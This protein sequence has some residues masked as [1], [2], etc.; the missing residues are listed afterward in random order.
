MKRSIFLILV[1]VLVA[2]LAMP[3]AASAQDVQAAAAA[4]TWKS[5]VMYFN[6]T[7]GGTGTGGETTMSIT[8]TG[9]VKNPDGSETPVSGSSDAQPVYAYQVGQVFIGTSGDFEGSAVISSGVPLVA[10]YKQFPAKNDDGSGDTNYSPLL[11]T[12]FDGST[13]A[14][15]GRFYIPTVLR[16]PTYISQVGV[17][18]VEPDL[19]PVDVTVHFLNTDGQEVGS[20]SRPDL[21]GGESFVFE[22]TGDVVGDMFDGSVVVDAVKSGTS[23]PG[24]IVAAVQ[25]LERSG[26]RGYAF[27]GAG[28]GA[29]AVYMPS[30]MCRYTTAL[31]T[32]YF[33]VQNAGDVEDTVLVDYYGPTGAKITTLTAGNVKP[34]AKLSINSCDSRI[35][36]RTTGKNALAVV[37]TQN[38]TPVVVV[39]KVSSRTGLSTAYLGLTTGAKRVLLPYL[40]MD[41]GRY[42]LRTYIAVMNAGTAPARDV[43]IR[44]YYKV[45]GSDPATYAYKEVKLATATRL[46]RPLAKISAQP[47]FPTTALVNNVYYGAA[48]II[49]D[50]PVVVVVRVQRAVAGVKGITT[51]GEDYDGIPDI[52]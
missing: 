33:A 44:Y 32:A 36:R 14:G 19:S 12:S 9:V 3:A 20:I 41:R 51:L 24:Q 49:S 2:T 13:Q 40:E 21:P 47:Q 29:A 16:T 7:A 46:L 25:E 1:F 10:T 43:R 45:A 18:N 34:G 8:W 15:L 17:Q 6:P 26:R 11:Y 5:A 38:G 42:G 4:P 27:E 35:L 39:G 28:S 23:D 48:E 22:P 52:Q 31:Q 50:Q 37:R 30:A